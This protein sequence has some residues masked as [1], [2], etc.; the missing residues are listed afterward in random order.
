MSIFD[1]FYLLFKADTTDLEKGIQKKD[2]LEAAS[3]DKSKK[4]NQEGQK[5]NKVAVRDMQNLQDQLKKSQDATE[6]LSV[7]F[8]DMAAQAASAL[9]AIVSIGAVSSSIFSSEKDVL[10]LK[11]FSDMLGLNMEQVGAWGYALRKEGGSAQVLEGDIKKLVIGLNTMSQFAGLPVDLGVSNLVRDLQANGID[12][13]DDAHKKV[14]DFNEVLLLEADYLHGMT[15]KVSAY[16]LSTEQYGNS[17]FMTRLLE[18]GRPAVEQFLQEGYAIGVATKKMGDSIENFVIEWNKFYQT[19]YVQGAT[20][21][22]SIIDFFTRLPELIHN[23]IQPLKEL[24]LAAL[25]ATGIFSVLYIEASAAL[26]E[27]AAAAIIAALPFLAF[28]GVVYALYEAFHYLDNQ[29]WF[30]KIIDAVTATGLLFDWL[31]SKLVKTLTL[32]SDIA[33]RKKSWGDVK[34]DYQNLI[35][36]DDLDPG[37]KEK[38]SKDYAVHRIFPGQ[39]LVNPEINPFDPAHTM[40]VASATIAAV[41]KMDISSQTNSSV[42]NRSSNFGGNSVQI[43]TIKIDTQAT[44][45]MGIAAGIS[46]A[47]VDMLSG[48]YSSA[49]MS[50]AT[51]QK[52]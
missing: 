18:H 21:G 45:A 13:V 40:R 3:A 25:V 29:P 27:M 24:G 49:T 34:K 37:G 14:K 23:N 51:G 42:Q 5:E 12:V 43:D 38:K 28:I 39:K 35:S 20:V 10:D 50:V 32:L 22:T 33:D 9:A 36:G 30:Q 26:V 15:D 47:L 48:H 2:K 41:Q 17:D 7:S 11:R 31:I 19:V 44:D 46:G 8:I 16:R 4:Q 1:S 6:G 52:G